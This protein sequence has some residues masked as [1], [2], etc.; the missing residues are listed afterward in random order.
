MDIDVDII[1]RDLAPLDSL[2]QTAGRCNRSGNKEKGVV[3]VISLKMRME[4][5]ILVLFM[6]L[7]Y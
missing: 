4:N 1:Y 7:F 2:V 3:N 6:I 5:H